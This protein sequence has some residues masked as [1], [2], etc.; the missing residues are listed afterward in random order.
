MNWPREQQTTGQFTHAAFQRALRV[1][2][3]VAR[4]TELQRTSCQHP[5]RGD[6]RLR[7]QIFERFDQ[8]QVLAIGAGEMAKESLRYLV[9]EEP[10]HHG[11]QPISRPRQ[12]LA[13][14][15]RASPTV[16]SSCRTTGHAD[17]VICATGADS[18]V[19]DQQIFA[20]CA[21]A[22]HQRPHVHSRLW[23]CPAMSTRPLP[24]VW[25]STY[26]R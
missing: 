18:F 25:A 13:R 8:K 5:Q 22:R 21:P 2:K 16:G 14:Q 6:S 15:F 19:I 3:R 17:L 11:D 1:A 10:A 4:E 23:P 20:D 7:R 26:T 9:D 12:E 24:T